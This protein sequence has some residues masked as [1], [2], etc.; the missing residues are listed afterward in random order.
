MPAIITS[1]GPSVEVAASASAAAAAESTDVF[2]PLPFFLLSFSL[3]ATPSSLLSLF[4]SS[5]LTVIAPPPLPTPPPPG[6]ANGI[7]LGILI[8]RL[9]RMTL[10][11]LLGGVG[12]ASSN[13][14]ATPTNAIVDIRL[15]RPKYGTMSS[16][17]VTS[18]VPKTNAHPIPS[19]LLFSAMPVAMV[20]SLLGNQDTNRRAGVHW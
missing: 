1:A 5:L 15:R 20:R 10:A 9:P 17:A 4:S 18:I 8:S 16:S 19:W 13:C 7:H 12:G 3:S 6:S 2:P 14:S 11:E